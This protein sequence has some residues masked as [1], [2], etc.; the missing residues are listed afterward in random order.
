[1]RKKKGIFFW[2]F[3]LITLT[4][5][6]FYSD[7]RSFS[8][9]FN[10]KKIEV[11]GISNI[12]EEQIMTKLNVLKGKNIISI[13]KKKISTIVKDFS[14]IEKII[15]KKIYPDK[16]KIIITELDPI[17]IF[18][19]ENKK[20]I[21]LQNGSSTTQYNQKN[22]INL[23]SVYGVEGDKNFYIFY[24]DLIK[25]SFD[26]TFIKEV[27]YFKTKRWDI[28]LKNDKLI[29]L[30]VMDYNKSLIKFNSLSK[31]DEFKNFKIFDFRV[32]GQLFLK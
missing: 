32:N 21:L 1:M 5:Y 19:E 29:R 10:L 22:L 4:T 27:R 26:I 13:N 14:Y 17:G 7:N 3:I 25:T 18:L 31:K 24:N 15:V 2:I 20:L 23:L 12:Q 8:T 16:I 6:N 11:S 30:P 9:Y 28:I